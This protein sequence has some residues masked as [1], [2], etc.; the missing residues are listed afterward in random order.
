MPA[1]A[2]R[3]K[4][5]RAL[6]RWLRRWADWLHDVPEPPEEEG[7]PPAHWVEKVRHAAPELLRGLKAR[8]PGRPP[9]EQDASAKV[10]EASPGAR[11]LVR[12]V[13]SGKVPAAAVPEKP[14]RPAPAAQVRADLHGA[15]PANA[16]V[17]AIQVPATRVPPVSPTQAKKS[18]AEVPSAKVPPAKV[19][20]V[21]MPPAKV[22]SVKVPAV[23]LF[24]AEVSGDSP[25]PPLSLPRQAAPSPPQHARPEKAVPL[26]LAP[27]APLERPSMPLPSPERWPSL[28][29]A[30]TG[31]PIAPSV[32]APGTLP[33]RPAPETPFVAPPSSWP[34]LPRMPALWPAPW[35][36]LRRELVRRARLDYEQRGE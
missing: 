5:A 31:E 18:S 9:V 14:P 15:V 26:R 33:E 16:P 17:P 21:K 10:S 24:A 28:D 30:Q 32:A 4:L 34:E 20:S 2:F 12:S 29:E 13:P 25:R 27:A 8:P 6:A 7:G 11:E 36:E 3:K 19:P 23:K 35:T 1:K 22:P